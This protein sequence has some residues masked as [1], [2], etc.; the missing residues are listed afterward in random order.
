MGH[1]HPESL[2]DLLPVIQDPWVALIFG[3]A[4]DVRVLIL[5]TL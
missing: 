2:A 4:G 5:V 3:V 1:P